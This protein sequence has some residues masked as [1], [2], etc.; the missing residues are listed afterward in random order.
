MPTGEN[1][2]A[3]DCIRT[4]LAATTRPNAKGRRDPLDDISKAHVFVTDKPRQADSVRLVVGVLSLRVLFAFLS[5]VT[6]SLG[7]F[8]GFGKRPRRLVGAAPQ[9]LD[10]VSGTVQRPA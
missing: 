1:E 9:W 3:I 5:H 4:A 10:A 6:S 7:L 2:P 8:A